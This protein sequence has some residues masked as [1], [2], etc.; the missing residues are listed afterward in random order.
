[1]ITVSLSYFLKLVQT[2]GKLCKPKANLQSESMIYIGAS[3][4]V[5]EEQ[6]FI[7][8]VRSGKVRLSLQVYTVCCLYFWLCLIEPSIVYTC[9]PNVYLKYCF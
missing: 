7:K 2:K 1:M 8:K 5:T 3:Y 9:R 6:I 4:E